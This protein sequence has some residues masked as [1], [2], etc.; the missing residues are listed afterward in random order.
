MAD[1]FLLAEPAGPRGGA[2]LAAG[3]DHPAYPQTIDPVPTE[4]QRSLLGDL[5]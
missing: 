4:L 5:R 2:S 1:C 3:I